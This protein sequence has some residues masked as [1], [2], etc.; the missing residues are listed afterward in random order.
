M[1]QCL[2]VF[3]LLVGTATSV[4]CVGDNTIALEGDCFC[5]T[6]PGLC[7]QNQYCYN[8]ECQNDPKPCDASFQN[9]VSND[10]ICGTET[11]VCNTGQFCYNE[12]C[13]S[14][15]YRTCTESYVYPLQ[16]DCVC[17]NEDELCAEHKWCY[18]GSCD[19]QARCK[20][21]DDPEKNIFYGAKLTGSWDSTS[22]KMSISLP[23]KWDIK[24][25]EIKWNNAQDGNILSYSL[26]QPGYW[27]KTQTNP[28]EPHY[29]LTID[30]NLFF[31]NGSRF[32]ITGNT[33][34]TYL[35]V[36]AETVIAKR[37]H[38]YEYQ[39]TRQITDSVPA[40][41]DLIKQ[42]K[43][44]CHF[45]TVIPAPKKFV[46]LEIIYTG[47][48]NDYFESNKANFVDAL[49]QILGQSSSTI[50]VHE[51]ETQNR[52]RRTSVGIKVT[53]HVSYNTDAQ[54][55]S[56]LSKAGAIDFNK[57]LETETK[58]QGVT[59]TFEIG[60]LIKEP[61]PFGFVFTL[62]ATNDYV[63]ISHPKVVIVMQVHTASCVDHV[64]NDENYA[65]GVRI[66]SGSNHIDTNIDSTFVWKMNAADDTQYLKT[67]QNNF[68]VET[69]TWTYQPSSYS[70]SAY[71]IALEF[72]VQGAEFTF[73]TIAS[74]DIQKADVLADIGF[75][76]QCFTYKDKAGTEKQKKFNLGDF[77]Y[78]KIEL[79]AL[80]VETES[81]ECKLM[82][83][84]QKK[85]GNSTTIKT[86]MKEKKVD[87]DEYSYNFYQ[88]PTLNNVV[89][90]GAELESHHFHVSSEGYDT[91]LEIQIEVT[92]EEGVQKN[93]TRRFLSIPIS[94]SMNDDAKLS[95][96]QRDADQK[97]VSTEIW[98]TDEVESNVGGENLIP[99]RISHLR[100]LILCIC[101]FTLMVLTYSSYPANKVEEYIPLMA[102]E[103]EL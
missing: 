95:T 5:G 15:A 96:P 8:G 43:V 6:E 44:R 27:V 90:C 35:K 84:V 55:D 50:T 86:N 25:K 18:D 17:G 48:S 73:K 31:G 100:I 83:V 91:T 3:L 98:I 40:K 53:Y 32:S 80:V 72:K 2:I 4:I 12:E 85:D 87:T 77:V 102:T 69:L 70:D 54:R 93:I 26:T 23:V 42:L 99:E 1:L 24:I 9:N 29:D 71:D 21:R 14:D 89:I 28:C 88:G 13:N 97:V 34:S 68:C 20:H 37:I 75:D 101:A 22:K 76:H 58:N 62:E 19:P 92:Y 47:I 78:V 64:K 59:E 52:R 10:C 74:I 66:V 82:D 39:Y 94:N 11:T 81:I 67:Y 56:I 61:E 46:I 45:K 33:M 63:D 60:V 16:N 7:E 57:K 103:M 79:S 49:A 38:G 30:Q 65:H 36:K 41:V 51:I